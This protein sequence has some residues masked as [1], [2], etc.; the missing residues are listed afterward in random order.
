MSGES[1]K[2]LFIDCMLKV[3]DESGRL[4]EAFDREVNVVKG[5]LKVMM[6]H[7]A[8]DIDTLVVETQITPF[9]IDDEKDT[10]SNLLLA[11]GNKPIMSQRES[12]EA[13]GQSNDVDQTMK[14]I[15]E[16]STQDVMAPY[17]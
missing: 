13:Y 7:M 10:I 12:I 11:N 3:K 5:W 1:R 6:P 4:L 8:T 17:A 16:E 15:A 9:T 14:E 2:Q